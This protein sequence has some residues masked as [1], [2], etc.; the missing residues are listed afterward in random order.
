VCVDDP[1]AQLGDQRG[2]PADPLHQ[3]RSREHVTGR[4]VDAGT[5][6]ARRRAR[7]AGH[8][9]HPPS[10]SSKIGAGNIMPGITDNA[11]ATVRPAPERASKPPPKTAKQTPRLPAGGP[12][13]TPGQQAAR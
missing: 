6:G 2:E 10:N 13:S 1:L 5:G 12:Q 8:E 7:H 4:H 11:P 9:H 3:H